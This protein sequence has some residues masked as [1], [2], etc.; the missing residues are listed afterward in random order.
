MKGRVSTLTIV[1]MSN[2]IIPLPPLGEQ[3]RIV[4]KIENLLLLSERYAVAWN[5]LESLNRKFPENLQKSI[6][7]E[8]IQGK[9]CEQKD[10]D[11]SA[12]ALIEKILLEKERLIESGQIKKHKALPAIQE[13]EIPFDI[14]DSWRW[15][16]L[17]ELVYNRGQKKPDTEFSYIDI[18][19][20]DNAHQK[21]TNLKNI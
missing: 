11:G 2:Y 1:R 7:Q 12:K 9:L 21:L 16:R 5:K 14:P 15:I 4:K 3:N 10:E 13:D 18:G 17:K 20:I 6:L 8:A 19:S